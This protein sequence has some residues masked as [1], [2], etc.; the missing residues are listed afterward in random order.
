M[1]EDGNFLTDIA[2]AIKVPTDITKAALEP[3]AKQIGEGLGDIFYMIF[4]PF[5][6][7]RINKEHEIQL[8]RNDLESEINK[9]P[10]EEVSE[11]P[12][13]IVGPA[14]EASKYY[15][16]NETIRKMFA[17][18]IASSVNVNTKDQTH[19]SFVDIVRQLSPFDAN[20]FK[21]L[22][23]C[24]STGV[25]VG[26]IKR[27]YI[28]E[29][30]E[31]T[32]IENFFPFP[33]MDLSNE[34]LYSA[35]VDNFIR[36]GLIQIDHELHYTYEWRYDDLYNHA[37]YKYYKQQQEHSNLALPEEKYQEVFLKKSIWDLTSFGKMF[38]QSCL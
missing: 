12:L 3:P 20:A 25:A 21:F 37:L 23:S 15:I 8:F 11:P 1:S 13:N 7:A 32:L 14:L 29:D 34:K 28:N 27:K 10:P 17:K 16:E 4:S 6:K 38:A 22:C 31:N 2:K 9:I 33:N 30:G 19:S 35:A 36:L 18:L 5:A 24:T 26:K